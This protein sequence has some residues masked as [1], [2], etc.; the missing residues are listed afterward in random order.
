MP[1]IGGWGGA[2][3][4]RRSG[5]VDIT[6]RVAEPR[7]PDDGAAGDRVVARR[8]VISAPAR[9]HALQS[10]FEM[11]L[12]RT[13]TGRRFSRKKQPSRSTPQHNASTRSR[14]GG[15][16][17]PRL[18]VDNWPGPR[19]ATGRS[20]ARHRGRS[21]G[22]R[23]KPSLSA[24]PWNTRRARCVQNVHG[25]GQNGRKWPHRRNDAFPPRLTPL[26]GQPIAVSCPPGGLRG[27]NWYLGAR[28]ADLVRTEKRPTSGDF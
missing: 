20:H 4:S 25:R 19:P 3:I 16:G 11:R 1:V 27:T 2:A 5:M 21:T 10:L 23:V 15:G 14:S 18:P 26:Y 9:N 28:V 22:A 13:T 8:G 12:T 24:K 7:A 17:M 6:D